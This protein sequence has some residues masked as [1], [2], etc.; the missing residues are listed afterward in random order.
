MTGVRTRPGI[1]ELR[2]AANAIRRRNLEI[3]H[4]AGLGHTGGDLSAADILTALYFA[5]LD[6]DPA[7]PDAPDRDRYI[8]SKGHASGVLYTTL[9]AAGFIP[10]SLHR[11][12]RSTAI[13][14][15]RRCPASRRTPDRSVT[16]SR[17]PSARRSP[18]SSTARAAGRSSCA[19]TASCRRAPTG[20]PSWPPPTTR[21]TTS[22]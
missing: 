4:A 13:P 1:G 16:D 22:C 17:L 7:Q 20:R 11:G 2:A 21:S 8:Q 5:V 10:D 9:A 19:A 6:V 18:P 14:I 12:R 3:I 15:A